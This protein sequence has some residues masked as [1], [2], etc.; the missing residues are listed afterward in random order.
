MRKIAYIF[1]YD[2]AIFHNYDQNPNRLI[3]WLLKGKVA[4]A[5]GG[6]KYVTAGC[7]YLAEYALKVNSNVVVIPTVID[8]DK[9]PKHGSKLKLVN[10]FTVGWIGSPSTVK[11]VEAIGMALTN[12]CNTNNVKIVLIGAGKVDLPGVNLEKIEW[13]EGSEIENV[14]M[15]DV[16]IM[17]LADS[18]FERGK[19]GFKLIQYMACGLPVVASPVGVN[20]NIVED[21]KNGFL[22]K[23]TEDWVRALTTLRDNKDL[24]QRMG[25]AGR[26]KVEEQYC[27]HVTAPKYLVLLQKILNEK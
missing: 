8:I 22:A 5:I 17:P 14:R 24:R 4:T 10:S 15:F 25:A 2:D 20:S 18:P 1:D 3:K 27:L 19:C 16:G 11:C 26:K 23:T 9:Y 13:S 6:A 21:G 12:I 7:Q